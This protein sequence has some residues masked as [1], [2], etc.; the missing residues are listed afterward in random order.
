MKHEILV[1]ILTLSSYTLTAQWVQLNDSTN[2]TI[3]AVHEYGGELFLGGFFDQLNGAAVSHSVYYNGSSFTGINTVL[4]TG[5]FRVMEEY[6]GDLYGG[7]DILEFGSIQGTAVW[8]GFD[9]QTGPMNTNNFIAVHDM[10]EWSGQLVMGGAFTIPSSYVAA[11]DGTTTTD[12]GNG[13]NSEVYALA[14]F[15]GEL[16]A[17]GSMTSSGV[18]T[19]SNIA[20]W[21][22]STWV[23]VGGGFDD[24][25]FQLEVHDGKLFASG[26]FTMAGGSPASRLASWDGTT[27]SQVGGGVIA[28]SSGAINVLEST[29]NGLLV[30]GKNMSAGGIT[31]ANLLLFNGLTWVELVGIPLNETVTQIAQFQGDVYVMTYGGFSDPVGRIYRGSTVSVQEANINDQLVLAPNPVTDDLILLNLGSAKGNWEIWDVSGRLVLEGSLVRRIDVSIL[32]Q[33]TYALRI[34]TPSGRTVHQFVKS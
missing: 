33:G 28:S 24:A 10:V 18:N 4:S 5:G 23:D 11:Y 13:F 26:Q 14:E 9:W 17:A 7:G 6:N 12:L 27:W 16:Y 34:S 29:V 32:P 20:R 15:N 1:L 8:D 30:G 21:D 25:C 3:T 31:G 2:G 19:L 22:G